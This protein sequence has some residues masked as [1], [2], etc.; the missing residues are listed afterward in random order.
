MVHRQVGGVAAV[1]A[2]HA[3]ELAVGTRKA[4]AHQG[5][6]DRQVEHLASSVS[7][8]EPPPRSRRHRSR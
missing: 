4:E 7:G 8:A 5:V 6:G 3:D 2:E 1:H